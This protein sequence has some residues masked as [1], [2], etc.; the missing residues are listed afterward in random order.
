MTCVKRIRKQLF[1]MIELALAI[2]ILAIAAISIISLFFL[3]LQENRNSIGD[4]YSAI[5]AEGIF[6][7]ISR[8]A[9]TEW[10]TLLTEIPSS[11]PNSELNST[12]GWVDH[13]GDVYNPPGSSLGVYGIK[14]LTNNMTEDFNAEILIWRKRP[15]DWSLP[16]DSGYKVRGDINC[17]PAGS[18]QNATVIYGTTQGTIYL[19]DQSFPFTYSGPAT[20]IYTRSKGSNKDVQL[21]N[22]SEGEDP[23][24]NIS[25]ELFQF[26]SGDM[27]II[28]NA[29]GS[30]SG[31]IT[32]TGNGTTI[33]P[34]PVRGI[35]ETS[36]AVFFE[37]S[38][39]VTKAY[40]LRKKRIYYFEIFDEDNV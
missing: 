4:N 20:T 27:T 33:I 39:P 7:Y 21:E 9:D 35:A 12:A 11:K 37:I 25:G 24:L 34:D 36:A 17:N 2:A 40:S 31:T 28:V 15:D 14:K 1:S 13:D 23:D 32:I 10:T 8:I 16:N 29:P 19:K 5:S 3:G 22:L 6:A 30:G 26:I 38:W 18:G